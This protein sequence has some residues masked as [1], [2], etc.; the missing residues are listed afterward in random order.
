PRP[1]AHRRGD[2]SLSRSLRA[3]FLRTESDENFE[4]IL[5]IPVSGAFRVCKE[6]CEPT[7]RYA[8]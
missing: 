2:A 3:R 4:R 8:F 6:N 7:K 1:V 5:S